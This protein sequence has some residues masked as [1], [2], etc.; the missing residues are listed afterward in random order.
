[1]GV[2]QRSWIP[3][4]LALAAI[5]APIAAPPAAAAAPAQD[6]PLSDFEAWWAAAER[7]DCKGALKLGEPLVRPGRSS[8]PDDARALVHAVVAECAYL[9]GDKAKAYDHAIRGTRFDEALDQLWE[10]RLWLELD[11]KRFEAAVASVEAMSQGRGAALNAMPR[12]WFWSLTKDLRD[13]S[14]ASLRKRLLRILGG[15]SYAPTASGGD[16]QGFQL[17]YAKLLAEEGDDEGAR[18]MLARIYDPG[19]LID[20]MFDPRLRGLL[21]ADL[22]LRASAEKAL[23]RDRERAALHPDLIDPIATVATH[24]QRLG[25]QAEA[26]TLLQSIESKV[27]APD[28]FAD[29]AEMLPWYWDSLSRIYTHLG[30]YEEAAAALRKGAEINEGSAP[31]VSQVINLAHLQLRFGRPEEVLKTLAVFD[32]PGRELS[33][34]GQMAMRIARGCAHAALGNMAAAAADLAYAEAHEKDS[35]EILTSLYLCVGR[36]DDAAAVLVRRL[37]DPELRSDALQE[38]SDF[39][40]WPG[41]VPLMPWEKPVEALKARADVKAAIERAGGTRRI[42]LQSTDL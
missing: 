27:D 20:S 41:N 9:E 31:N 8:L 3:I 16:A 38:L 5:V 11:S 18:A 28:A 10:L 21:P 26:L 15:G 23:A 32:G 13:S 4:R 36:I 19:L 40:P 39:E 7:D 6:E 17:E 34:Y 1:M 35:P 14:Q 24:L 22:D 33:E 12:Q 2:V 37:D 25:R 42:P 29:R 30:R